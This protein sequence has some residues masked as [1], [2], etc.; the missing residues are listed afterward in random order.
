MHLKKLMENMIHVEKLAQYVKTME[1]SRERALSSIIVLIQED[2]QPMVNIIQ[3]GSSTGAQKQQNYAMGVNPCPMVAS[4][5]HTFITDSMKP[6]NGHII[7]DLFELW[8]ISTPHEDTLILVLPVR[9]HLV[10]CI[11]VDLG[12]V[13][14]LLYLPAFLQMGYK[15]DV[16]HTLRRILIGFNGS[17]TFLY[18]R[19]RATSNCRTSNH[20]H[21]ILCCKRSVFL[22]YHTQ[23]T[24]IH[25]MKAIPSSYHHKIS[26][27]T[28]HG[29]VDL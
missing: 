10:H 18:R 5:Q 21:S 3:V 8:S 16:L 11:L 7:F 20:V 24:W 29:Q 13:V 12:N 1:S 15:V 2:T 19:N 23:R 22:E 26:F 9:G 6:I 14:D 17:K 28:E 25:K 4:I 27:L